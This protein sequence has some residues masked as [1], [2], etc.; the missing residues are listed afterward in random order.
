MNRWSLG[1]ALL[2]LAAVSGC[3]RLLMPPER[4]VY[5]AQEEGL[6]LSYEDPGS[7][8]R[9]QVRVKEARPEGAG[10]RV[11]QT[12]SSLSGQFDARFLQRDGGL[13]LQAGGPAGLELLPEGFPDRVS[14][15]E[16]R[17]S[18]H[19]VVGRA[20]ADLPGV[21]LADPAGAEGVW[22]ESS[23][24]DGTGPRERTF[25]L[26]GIGEAETRSWIGGRWVVINRLV[27]RGF[28]DL[29]GASQAKPSGSNP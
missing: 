4:P 19:W 9:L 7:H 21:R 28:T 27:A 18:F 2:A 22:V 13:V 16:A 26:P 1:A 14:R 25:Y 11:I 15:W 6:T 8:A 24:V 23:R 3:D 29:P 17:G 10:L 12:Y 5:F 20:A